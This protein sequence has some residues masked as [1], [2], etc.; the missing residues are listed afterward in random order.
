MWCTCIRVIVCVWLC[1]C[2]CD[3]VCLW[4]WIWYV[5]SSVNFVSGGW[6]L[7]IS[8]LDMSLWILKRCYTIMLTVLCKHRAICAL[9]ASHVAKVYTVNR[10]SS[11]PSEQCAIEYS[12]TLPHMYLYKIS[13]NSPLPNHAE[14]LPLK[15]VPVMLNAVHLS[16]CTL[17]IQ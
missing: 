1:V 10:T 5:S 13:I 11:S 9:R 8:W 2:D 16:R 7:I 6:W 14:C 17:V 4:V 15:F 12:Y 3:C